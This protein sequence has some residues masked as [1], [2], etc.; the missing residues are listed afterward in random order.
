MKKTPRPA[1]SRRERQIMDILYREG[2]ATANEVMTSL[3][4]EP[5]LSTVRTQLRILEAKGYVRHKEEGLRYVYLPAVQQDK[6]KQ[7][8]LKN[9]MDAFFDGSAAQVMT[10]LFDMSAGNLTD[11]EMADLQRLID[12]AMKGRKQS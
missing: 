10:A 11:K 2:R 4:G 3:S 5:H 12:K 1:L 6:L 7:S 8:V 9:M